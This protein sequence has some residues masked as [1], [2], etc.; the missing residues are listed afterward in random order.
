[1]H[2]RGVKCGQKP[3]RRTTEDGRREMERE[4]DGKVMLRERLAEEESN[5]YVKIGGSYGLGVE[6]GGNASRRSICE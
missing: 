4:R 2:D 6:D 3:R 5:M 1:M